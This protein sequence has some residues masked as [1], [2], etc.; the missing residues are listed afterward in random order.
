MSEEWPIALDERAKKRIRQI[1]KEQETTVYEVIWVLVEE[2]S[3]DYFRG[4][5]D[6]PARL[7]E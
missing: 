4:R 6:D 3:L 5:A 2:G 7:V 1:P